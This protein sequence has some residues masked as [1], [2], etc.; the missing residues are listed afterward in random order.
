MDLCDRPAACGLRDGK[1][2]PLLPDLLDS[3]AIWDDTTVIGDAFFCLAE[4][5]CSAFHLCIV[6]LCNM[7]YSISTS[8]PLNPIYLKGKRREKNV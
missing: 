3:T 4:K 8:L 5:F 6:Q 1:S 2:D 7:L